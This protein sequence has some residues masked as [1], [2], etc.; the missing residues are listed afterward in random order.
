VRRALNIPDHVQPW[1]E[2]ND[3]ISKK[4]S[5]QYEGSFWIYKIMKQYGYKMLFYSGD[6]DGAVPTFGTR[7]W[8]QMLNWKV[9]TNWYPWFTDG[10]VSGYFISYDGLDFAT[11]HGV[12]HLAPQWK[13][14]DVT[15]L[16]SNWIHNEPVK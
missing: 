14:K 16:F 15:K 2:C 11:I 13:R 9:K 10:Q 1:S 12:G 4:Y 6:T 7:R 8:I 5:Y 3:I